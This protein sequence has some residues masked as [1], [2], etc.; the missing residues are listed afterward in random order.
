MRLPG[1]A[2]DPEFWVGGGFVVD[3]VNELTQVFD[4][5]Q[6]NC[7]V[8]SPVKAKNWPQAVDMDVGTTT[9]Q[10]SESTNM[11]GLVFEQQYADGSCDI[12]LVERQ[13]DFDVSRVTTVDVSSAS[14][15]DKVLPVIFTCVVVVC[16]VLSD[17]FARN[18]LLTRSSHL[19]LKIRQVRVA[20][21]QKS[22]RQRATK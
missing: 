4:V 14:L 18:G 5:Q 22:S 3:V 2:I 20:K 15:I 21:G 6:K 1:V 12:S 16:T 11:P 13:P 19:L 9:R 8:V 10:A 7:S 17:A